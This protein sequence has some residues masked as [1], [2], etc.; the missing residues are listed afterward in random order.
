M[1]RKGGAA[2]SAAGRHPTETRGSDGGVSGEGAADAAAAAAAAGTEGNSKMKSSPLLL[3]E[4]ILVLSP[5][6]KLLSL[7]LSPPF[8]DLSPLL[9]L[10]SLFWFQSRWEFGEKTR[11]RGKVNLVVFFFF[12][13]LLQEPLLFLWLLCLLSL[14]RSGRRCCPCSGFGQ[15]CCPCSGFGRR[16]CPCSGFG[17]RSSRAASVWRKR[18]GE[19][20]RK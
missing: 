5:P 18:E 10:L 15:R 8:H 14:L 9:L 16:C 17:R 6:F 4:L 11:G 3:F 13:L 7:L 19:R 12:F 1:E 2:A 20:E